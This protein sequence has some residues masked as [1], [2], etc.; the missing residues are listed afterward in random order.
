MEAPKTEKPK[1]SRSK[2]VLFIGAGIV[3]LCIICTII[4]VLVQPTLDN[5][6]EVVSQPEQPERQE[7]SSTPTLKEESATADAPT[8]S[9]P[10]PTSDTSVFNV[11]D[12]ISIGD[13]VLIVLGWEEIS[14][15]EF[16]KP[17]EGNKF[18]AVEIL[19]VNQSS[20][21]ISISSLLQM[22]LKDDTAQ[23]YDIDLL[24]STATNS[25][26]ID[27]ELS[28]GERI[29][30][31]VGFQVPVNVQ[32]LQFVFDADVFGAGKAI[33]N[34]GSAP[35]QVAPPAEIIGET[36][37]QIFNVGDVIEIDTFVLT[38][39]EVTFPSGDDSNKPSEGNKF[40]VVDLTI[41]N[42]D[43]STAAISTLLQ[44]SVKD[45]AGRNYDLDISAQMASG[46]TS[47][48]GELAPGERVRGQVGFQVPVDAT[49]LVFVFD[50]DVFGAGKIFVALP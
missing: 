40:L 12:V 10:T 48:D 1:A 38:I 35:I 4:G 2:R 24:A 20:D 33:V 5:T 22:S 19:L 36:E 7:A 45:S 15:D 34:L 8:P 17:D 16:A 13:N 32:G 25:S 21:A 3:A 23:K 11:G 42:R 37:Q 43:T 30:G 39:N 6:S 27:G 41:E 26:S 9:P 18:I 14:G 28:P 50:A 49:E 46:G 44:T 31:Q 47:P 29:R